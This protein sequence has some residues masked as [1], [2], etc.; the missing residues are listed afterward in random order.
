MPDENEPL[1]LASALQHLAV[2]L[3]GVLL[4]YVSA[5]IAAMDF[6]PE[7]WGEVVR[8]FAEILFGGWLVLYVDAARS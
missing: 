5:S 6:D 8:I 4:C 7:R 1:T 2:F 3:G